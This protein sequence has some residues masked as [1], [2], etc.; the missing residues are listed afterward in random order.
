M[1]CRW[2]SLT[3]SYHLHTG[4]CMLLFGV[5]SRL[6]LLAIGWKDGISTLRRLIC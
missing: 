2:I 1:Q 4:G 5:A 6:P 3:A